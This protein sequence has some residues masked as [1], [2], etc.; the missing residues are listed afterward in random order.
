MD[1]LEQSFNIRYHYKIFFTE[2]LFDSDNL[3][4]AD[5]FN[6]ESSAA[7]KK[8]LF[9][10]D[11]GLVDANPALETA[12]TAY[13]QVHRAVELVSE[14]LIVPGG[15]AAKNNP[16]VL[17]SIIEAVDVHGIDRHSY[18]AAVG[19]GAVLDLVGYAAAIAHRGIRHLRI[20]TTVLAQ[21]DSGVGVKNGV[22]YKG[23]K[24]FLGSFSPPVAV[25]NDKQFL[26]TLNNRDFRSGISEAIKVALIKDP[27]FFTWI[28]A[29]ASK[30]LNRDMESME[31]LIKHCARLHL[32]HISSLDPFER[33]S[34]RPLDFGHW[35]AHKLEQLS[36][37]SITHGEAVAMGMALD[38]TY[39]LYAGVLSEEKLQRILNL[40]ALFFD[41]TNPLIRITDLNAPILQG[42]QEFREHLGGNLCI[43]LLRDVGE[44]FEV[45]EMD[46]HTLLQASQYILQFKKRQ[47]DTNTF[48]L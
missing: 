11:A 16:A 1:Y 38:S 12:I 23:K 25:F 5:F 29:H 8:V 14:I 7:Q 10:L 4:L 36:N 33:G 40:L 3:L 19:G 15:E 47:F 43:T 30:L 32:E 13:F 6:G 21:N 18:I 42:L 9:V 45:H 39:S 48:P 22:N 24:N 17:E 35:S 44:G 20:P 37:F 34:S 41:I 2:G 27:A 31:Y 28:E 26:L 46:P